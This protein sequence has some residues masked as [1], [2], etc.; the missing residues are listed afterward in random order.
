[1][2]ACVTAAVAQLAPQLEFLIIGYWDDSALNEVRSS[3]PTL[4][5]R[6]R[7]LRSDPGCS[8]KQVGIEHA[9]GKYVAFV[10]DETLVALQ[11][12]TFHEYV[13]M[14]VLGESA[15]SEI[16]CAGIYASCPDDVEQDVKA[17]RM[18]RSFNMSGTEI[19]ARV[20]ERARLPMR[21]DVRYEGKLF[22]RQLLLRCPDCFPTVNVHDDMLPLLFMGL[23]RR[24]CVIDGECVAP[25][26]RIAQQWDGIVSCVVNLKTQLTSYNLYHG[27]ENQFVRYFGFWLFNI[28]LLFLQAQSSAAAEAQSEMQDWIRKLFAEE[29]TRL[30]TLSYLA[31]PEKADER[32]C[33][34]T[35]RNHCYD[36]IL[37][38]GHKKFT[39][40]RQEGGS[41]LQN[42]DKTE[43][44]GLVTIVTVIKDTFRNGRRDYFEKMLSSVAAQDYGRDRI[45]HVFID[46]GSKDGTVEFLRE[47]TA[48]GS[49]DYWVSEPDGGIYNAMN[50]GA[51][52]ALGEFILYLNSDDI[53]TADAVSRL[54][55][56]L[57]NEDGDYAYA[58]AGFIDENEQI[59]GQ[60]RGNI[61]TVFFGSPYCHQ[62][63]LCK[64][65]C[66]D[67]LKYNE[68]F[69]ITMWQ[70]AIDL[71]L[72]ELRAVHVNRLV[73]FFRVGGVSTGVSSRERFFRE[74]D[75]IR[76][77]F[78]LP[79]IRL[80]YEEYMYIDTAF[81]GGDVAQYTEIDVAG[82]YDRLLHMS[83]SSNSF[84]KLF[85]ECTLHL[86]E[87]SCEDSGQPP[88]LRSLL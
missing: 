55:S 44:R 8:L 83:K 50:K 27:I 64:K 56:A 74:Q 35:L 65:Q 85:G 49:I 32:L 15:G 40:K 73:A 42:L 60:Q 48:A 16:V 37:N 39:D 29:T 53:L 88:M 78:I 38:P 31:L 3:L 51:A 14:A 5:D 10:D 79:R 23:S 62:T 22:I 80:S 33:W 6:V 2:G 86:V 25:S 18:P 41:R 4:H 26:D 47:L 46:A 71:F 28:R 52:M 20:L 76:R 43:V 12:N 57:Q 69:N 19:V 34:A 66:F 67:A 81:R 63:L 70:Y 45:E 21:I 54:V 58:D 68:H 13:R 24:V 9:L 72:S 77:N 84:E 87:L 59:V 11:Q 61:N 30:L 75:N 1:M 82:V 36:E 7:L 17:S